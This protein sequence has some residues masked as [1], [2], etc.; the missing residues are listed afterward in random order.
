VLIL[1]MVWLV[2][3]FRWLHLDDPN[4]ALPE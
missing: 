3:V 1:V 2:A 4:L